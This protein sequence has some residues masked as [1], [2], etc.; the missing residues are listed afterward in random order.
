MHLIECARVLVFS[1]SCTYFLGI[2][3]VSEVFAEVSM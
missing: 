3:F 1:V 2:F